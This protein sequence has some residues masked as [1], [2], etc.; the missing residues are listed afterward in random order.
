MKLLLVGYFGILKSTIIKVIDMDTFTFYTAIVFF[1]LLS[2]IIGGIYT[3]MKTKKLKEQLDREVRGFNRQLKLLN[4]SVYGNVGN[5]CQG[6]IERRLASLELNE[7]KTS[8]NVANLQVDAKNC[9]GAINK[10]AK[11]INYSKSNI[12]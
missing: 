2:F 3:D 11:H 8:L 5:N 4:N 12:V 9:K 1:S 7:D 6:S 10:L